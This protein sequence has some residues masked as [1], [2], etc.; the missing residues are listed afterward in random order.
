MGL[1][2]TGAPW[3]SPALA[4][5]ASAAVSWRDVGACWL[6]GGAVRARVYCSNSMLLSGPFAKVRAALR[7]LGQA[8]SRTKCRRFIGEPI[9]KRYLPVPMT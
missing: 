5:H 3:N 8:A 1:L 6:Y 4:I 2:P 7:Q 9:P